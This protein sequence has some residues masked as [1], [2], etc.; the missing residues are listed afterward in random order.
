MASKAC[1]FHLTPL[2]L[3]NTTGYQERSQVTLSRTPSKPQIM[4]G[5]RQPASDRSCIHFAPTSSSRASTAWVAVMSSLVSSSQVS[6]V[7]A[8][9]EWKS[10]IECSRFDEF[11]D[12]AT[13]DSFATL[14]GEPFDQFRGLIRFERARGHG[15]V[16]PAGG[17]LP[18][19]ILWKCESEPSSA[20]RGVTTMPEP[21]R[22][23]GGGHVGDGG[24]ERVSQTLDG[25]RRHG[26]QG[27]LDLRPAGLDG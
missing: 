26:S 15:A 12:Q 3:I 7:R 16:T 23:I 2:V 11:K 9:C 22:R 18:G 27:G 20:W 4:S 6:T 24:V 25:S 13:G 21:S 1:I 8:G 5:A 10:A 14:I 17:G 19:R